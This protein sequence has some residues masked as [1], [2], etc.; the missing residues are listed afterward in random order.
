MLIFKS[1]DN[2]IIMKKFLIIFISLV[3]TLSVQANEKH[4]KQFDKWLV[5]NKF[6]EFVKLEIGQPEGKCKSL[7]KI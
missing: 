1:R 5:K 2:N 7:K 3:L 4:L 6:T